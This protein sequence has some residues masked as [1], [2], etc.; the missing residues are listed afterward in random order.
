MAAD[1]SVYIAQRSV[2][3]T[4]FND[5]PQYR[6]TKVLEVAKLPGA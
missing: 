4:R 6:S 3:T 2:A 5:E 1:P